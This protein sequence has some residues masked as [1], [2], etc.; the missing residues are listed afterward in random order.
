MK[1]RSLATLLVVIMILTMFPVISSASEFTDMPDDWST[2]SLENAVNNG[3]L[4]GANGKIMAKDN[5]TRAQMATI[6]NR[7]FGAEREGPVE[8]FTDVVKG[9]WFYKEMTKAIAMETF[10]GS[11]NKLNPNDPITREQAFLVIARALNLK[12]T[13][14]MP[15]GFSD[16][17]EISSWAKGEVYSLVNEGYVRGSN[18][19]LNPQGYMT[20]AEFAQLMDNL[21]KVY[22]SEEGT[23]TRDIDGSL[24]VNKA[25]VIL[26]GITVSGDLIIGDAVK[27]HEVTIEDTNIIGRI[28]VRNSGEDSVLRLNQ[29]I[30]MIYSDA[31]KYGA[32][33]KIEDIEQAYENSKEKG[34]KGEFVTKSQC[35]SMIMAAFDLSQGPIGNNKRI[36]VF[37]LDYENSNGGSIKQLSSLGI[38]TEDEID[39]KAQITKGELNRILSKIH[40][41]IGTN[42]KDDFYAAVNKEWLDKDLPEGYR[43]F[44]LIDENDKIKNERIAAMIL[45]IVESDPE[46]GTIDQRIKD[47]YNSYLNH[48]KREEI[49]IEPIREYLE[50]ID[51]STSIQELLDVEALINNELTLQ[52]VIRWYVFRDETD[53]R[54][55]SLY[56]EGIPNL[57]LKNRLLDGDDEFTQDYLKYL[58]GVLELFGGKEGDVDK[59]YKLEKD[60][61]SYSLTTEEYWDL[62]KSYNPY[63]KEEMGKFFSAFDFDKL[64]KA[65]GFGEVDEVIIHNEGAVKRLGQLLVEENLDIFKNMAKV[66]VYHQ[67][68][69]LFVGKYAVPADVFY[70]KVYGYESNKYTKEE[71]IDNV[72]VYFPDDIEKMYVEKYLPDTGKDDLKKMISNINTEYKIMIEENKWLSDEAKRK[73]IEKI[74]GITFKLGYPEEWDISGDN[75]LIKA[76]RFMDNAISSSKLTNDKLIESL[77]EKPVNRDKWQFWYP[78]MEGEYN[79]EVNEI[80]LSSKYL[81]GELYNIA[82]SREENLGSIGVMIARE[83]AHSFD[84]DGSNKDKYGRENP[85]WTAED[86]VKFKEISKDV[87]ICFDGKEV[88]PGIFSQGIHTLNENIADITGLKIALAVCMKDQNA[89]LEAFFESYAKSYKTIVDREAAEDGSENS[90]YSLAK[91][92]VNRVLS[93]I[94]EFY[95][96]YGIEKGDDMYIP[97][98]LRVSIW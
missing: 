10:Q 91:L 7:A 70:E 89:D 6:I 67:I 63:T 22:I 65:Y 18:G 26:K 79:L 61:A 4:T 83:I 11:G 74:N 54:K 31:I 20:R 19:K 46:N 29:I 53:S 71:A 40:T 75:L 37:E 28:I 41:Y 30:D 5:L 50:G 45:E 90:K 66:N 39:G 56:F 44:S 13:S 97:K 80:V 59:L 92:R 36:G 2:A 3:L 48:E 78:P 73:A 62:D 21:I 9:H 98:E 69:V 1:K 82:S 32:K 84:E 47:F 76:D 94:D 14:V 81:Q 38:L 64:M 34:I 87:E 93:Q 88:M 52:P 68:S 57:I 23:Y 35:Y 16:L 51:A 85:W 77:Y 17:S 27:N 12:A 25:G 95:S 43:Q 72:K 86:R 55:N 33:I 58:T 42:K 96:T 8:R 49:A 60:I 24:M 15:E